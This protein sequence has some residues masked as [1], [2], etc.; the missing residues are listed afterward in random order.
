MLRTHGPLC[1]CHLSQV[2]SAYVNHTGTD[3]LVS[4]H[5]KT[6]GYRKKVLGKSPS[7]SRQVD[8]V[9]EAQLSVSGTRFRRT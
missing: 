8:H 2:S 5:C 4:K 9:R 6:S 3:K 7:S 1:V